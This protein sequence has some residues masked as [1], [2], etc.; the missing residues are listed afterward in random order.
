MKPG[1]ILATS[2]QSSKNLGTFTRTQ[3]SKQVSTPTA[4]KDVSGQ[5][6]H[7]LSPIP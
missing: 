5:D 7:L 2:P 3:L 1:T 6:R 4:V